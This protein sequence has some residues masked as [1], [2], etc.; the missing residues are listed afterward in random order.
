[1]VNMS[2]SSPSGGGVL[3][4]KKDAM[5]ASGPIRNGFGPTMFNWSGQ[6]QRTSKGCRSASHK[7]S[8][9]VQA[10]EVRMKPT[11]R[12]AVSWLY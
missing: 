8:G 11:T 1:M 2:G 10:L 5:D 7:A 4:E 12:Q 3:T 9:Q 6:K